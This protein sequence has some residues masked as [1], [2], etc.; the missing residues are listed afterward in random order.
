MITAVTRPDIPTTPAIMI[1]IMPRKMNLGCIAHTAKTP[2]EDLAVPW[3]EP[4][5]VNARAQAIP[6]NEKKLAV[7]TQWAIPAVRAC[8]FWRRE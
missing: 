1:G 7:T 3:P 6:K 5:A 8:E 4:M 2:M